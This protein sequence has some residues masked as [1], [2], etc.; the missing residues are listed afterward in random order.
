MSFDGNT[1]K[2]GPGW[3]ASG[4]GCHRRFEK[5]G[6]MVA[7]CGHPTANWPWA[8]FGPDARL[9]TSGEACNW[10]YAFAYAA[11]ARAHVERHLGGD[12]QHTPFLVGRE[13]AR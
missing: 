1:T 12:L 3:V 4:K 10:G 6:W 2:L 7:H 13:A 5:A 9:H 8:V 11:D